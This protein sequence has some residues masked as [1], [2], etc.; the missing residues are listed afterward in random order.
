MWQAMG[1]VHQIELN[2][3]SFT[4]GDGGMN[5][6]IKVLDAMAGTQHSTSGRY[7]GW[8]LDSFRVL[9]EHK[10]IS[11]LNEVLTLNWGC[12]LFYYYAPNCSSQVEGDREMY[13]FCSG[14]ETEAWG[15]HSLSSQRW[16]ISVNWKTFIHSFKRDSFIIGHLL[17]ARPC[18]LA[19]TVKKAGWAK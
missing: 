3:T 11:T 4:W 2:N 6:L 15:A 10:A 8:L 19:S 13:L 7:D 12:S 18:L 1:L 14:L 5:S 17:H 9:Q 16:K